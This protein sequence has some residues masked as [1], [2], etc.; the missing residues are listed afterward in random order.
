MKHWFENH[1]CR[2]ST[3]RSPI[4]L[5][6]DVRAA[7]E[8]S[9]VVNRMALLDSQHTTCAILVDELE[10]GIARDLEVLIQLPGE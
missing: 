3:A 9:G 4:D 2:P 6:H 1:I 8:R 7:V 5:A 10:D